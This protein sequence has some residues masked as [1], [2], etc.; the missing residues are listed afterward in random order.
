MGDRLRRLA[1]ASVSDWRYPAALA[2][3]IFSVVLAF[4][5]YRQWTSENDAHGLTE[6]VIAQNNDLRKQIEAVQVVTACRAQ[7]LSDVNVT[8]GHAV[9]IHGEESSAIGALIV[10]LFHQDKDALAAG[11]A[12]LDEIN[13]AAEA[14]NAAYQDALDRQ[15]AVSSLCDNTTGS[16]TTAP[17]Q[18]HP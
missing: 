1:V 4:T 13:Q 7:I 6:I 11:V 3:L 17:S 16:T 8:F 9:Q 12:Q 2:I 10:A 18:E 14:A 15:A 5:Q